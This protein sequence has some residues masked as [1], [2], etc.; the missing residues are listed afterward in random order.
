MGR[1]WKLWK[2]KLMVLTTGLCKVE[3]KLGLVKA[4]LNYIQYTY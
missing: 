3:Q 4:I 2:I 1:T